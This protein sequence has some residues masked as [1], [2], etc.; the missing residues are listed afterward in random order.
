MRF[1]DYFTAMPKKIS[2]AKIACL[3]FN[4]QKTKM[5]LGIQILITDPTKLDAIR[6]RWLIYRKSVT[7]Y[8]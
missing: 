7:H 4:L 6:E 5:H 3:D 1:I 2:G 8:I